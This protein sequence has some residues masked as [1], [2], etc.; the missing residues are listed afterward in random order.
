[1]KRVWWIVLLGA[2]LACLDSP[3]PGL[4]KV[5]L[6]TPNG[7]ADGAILLTVTGPEVLRSATPKAGLRL[8]NQSLATTN[9]FAV[10]GTLVNGT[11]LTIEVPDIAKANNYA[12]TIQQVAASN[13]QLRALAGYSLSVAP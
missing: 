7:G 4:L 2:A 6:T 1:M 12:A 5:N 8:F 9:H 11:I 13:Y 3:T 10:T